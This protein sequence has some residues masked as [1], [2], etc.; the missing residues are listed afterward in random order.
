MQPRPASSV[1]RPAFVALAVLALTV[2]LSAC[3]FAAEVGTRSWNL[4]T[5]NQDGTEHTI[6]VTDQSGRVGDV[7]FTPPDAD[8]RE[9]VS[10]SPSTPNALD[11]AWTGGACDAA[12]TLD[13]VAVGAGL[14]V[15]VAIED[16]GMPCDAMGLPQV[17]RL[18]FA[19]PIAP[20]MVR[21]TQ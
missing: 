3:G 5:T 17:V 12:T 6:T 9:S 15:G 4:T 19:E 11:V 7:D 2:A 8:L 14:E 1:R 16:N 21:I 10:V 20:A 18:T 13:I